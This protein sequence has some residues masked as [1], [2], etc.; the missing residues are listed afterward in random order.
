MNRQSMQQL[1]LD[2]RLID[3][4]DWISRQE[5]ERE[6]EALPDGAHKAMTL[7]QAEDEAKPTAEPPAPS[8]DPLASA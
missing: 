4:R 1:R 8:G 3:R 6:L 7:G 5:L 2:R